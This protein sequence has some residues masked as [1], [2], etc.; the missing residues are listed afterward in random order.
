[1][2][3]GFSKKIWGDKTPTIEERFWIRVVKLGDNKCWEWTGDKE[4]KMGYGLFLR[5]VVDLGKS[6]RAHRYSYEL[7]KGKIPKGLVIDHLCRNKSCVNPEHLE[8]VT[9][10]EN[11][12]RGKSFSAVNARKTHCSKGHPLSGSNLRL[13]KNR[14]K[15]DGTYYISRRCITCVRE[16]DKNY[17]KQPL[18]SRNN[19]QGE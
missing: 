4:K 12:L 9:Y 11:T 18:T 17:R 19:N 1:M 3:V 5:R 6:V 15:K 8:A 10:K 13:K 16:Y 14:L 7:H 2:P